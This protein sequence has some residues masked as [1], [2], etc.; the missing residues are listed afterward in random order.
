MVEYIVAID[1]TR[2]RFPAD[3]WFLPENQ[4]KS[5]NK[6]LPNCKKLGPR[7]KGEDV[8]RGE[9]GEMPRGTCEHKSLVF[10][11]VLALRCSSSLFPDQAMHGLGA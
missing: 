10:A 11:S 5:E 3:A 1:V 7:R 4:A 9:I 6:N 2:V 8:G